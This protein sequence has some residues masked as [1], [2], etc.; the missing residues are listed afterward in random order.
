MIGAEESVKKALMEVGGK[1]TSTKIAQALG[2]EISK[3][4][5]DPLKLL[6]KSMTEQK[7]LSLNGSVYS[8][9]DSSTAIV[10]ATTKA[11]KPKGERIKTK[12]SQPRIGLTP[13]ALVDA[14]VAL[15]KGR[16]YP[17]DR[18]TIAKQIGLK[19]TKDFTEQ[20]ALNVKNGVI[21][22]G[23]AG[24]SPKY[25]LAGDDPRYAQK[26]DESLK[27]ELLDEIQDLQ[28]EIGRL[29]AIQDLESSSKLESPVA[30]TVNDRIL[31]ALAE[32]AQKKKRRSVEIWALRAELN[33]LG[34][35]V[36]VEALE[37]LGSERLIE[38]VPVHDSTKLNRKQREG[39]LELSDGA[40]IASAAIHE[41]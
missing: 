3:S 11:P 6:L 39:L 4:K 35:E 9:P 15:K 17:A 25:M 29:S 19:A 14:L 10:S 34:P 38:L 37:R 28:A 26:A 16:Q 7:M 13:D 40:L 20:I 2:V 23:Q 33:D 12:S 36:L 18:T 41:K 31:R 5:S 30:P 22:V 1:G 8:L 24:K 21:V 32:L 27:F